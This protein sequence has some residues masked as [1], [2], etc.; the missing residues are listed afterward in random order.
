MIVL[1]TKAITCTKSHT[2]GVFA[3]TLCIRMHQHSSPLHAVQRG[4]SEMV[5]KQIITKEKKFI[6]AKCSINQFWVC[7]PSCVNGYG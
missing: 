5:E 1:L 6:C 7:D 3:D 4:K 2:G